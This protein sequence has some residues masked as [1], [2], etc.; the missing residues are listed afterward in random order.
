M[1]TNIIYLFIG[2]VIGGAIIKNCTPQAVETINFQTPNITKKITDTVIKHYSVEIPIEIPK[3][4]KDTIKENDLKIELLERE[5]RI[6]N[7]E[8]EFKE[9]LNDFNI[10]D[11]T[12]K[13]E[14]FKKAKELKAFESVQEDE[15]IIFNTKGIVA[16]EVKEIETFYKIKS[17]NYSIP[18]KV[19]KFSLSAGVATDLSA[20]TFL[21]FGVGYKNYKIDYLPSQ[22]IGIFSY[23]I[24]F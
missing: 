1:K 22:K 4:Y 9:I 5:N 7:Y 3:W 19:K 21:K 20:N 2:I 24:K 14:M 6:V 11:S 18:V 16:G 23:E 17:Q 12:L 8:S 15:N 10:A 13:S